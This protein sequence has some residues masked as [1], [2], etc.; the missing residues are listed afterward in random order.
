MMFNKILVVLDATQPQSCVFSI[1]LSYAKLF[2]SEVLLLHYVPTSPKPLFEENDIHQVPM[3]AK[4][5][6]EATTKLRSL[7]KIANELDLDISFADFNEQREQ[8]L[9]QFA[10]QW[11][12]DL[13]LIDPTDF[14]D[15]PEA[16]QNDTI[17]NAPC[18]VLLVQRPDWGS[19]ISMRMIVK[20]KQ[21]C[22][23]D[24]AREQLEALLALTPDQ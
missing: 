12:S 3:T 9:W 11:N 22:D 1:A 19:T 20:R 5:N 4:R 17:R 13:I 8:N 7:Q 24:S 18:S 14:S 2:Q 21:P 23:V 15:E 6:G 10:Y 16:L